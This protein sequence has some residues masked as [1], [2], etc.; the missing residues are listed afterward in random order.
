MCSDPNNPRAIYGGIDQLF[1]DDND[2]DDVLVSPRT[3]SYASAPNLSSSITYSTL[4]DDS[5]TI[6]AAVYDKFDP[7]F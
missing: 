4:G 6:P 7:K 5:N 1:T 3:S 2:D